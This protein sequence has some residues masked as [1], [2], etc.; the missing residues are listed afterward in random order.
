MAK[1]IERLEIS[2]LFEAMYRLYG[3]DFRDYAYASSR[4]RVLL[5]LQQKKL[6]NVSQLIH[7][8]MH[9]EIAADDLLLALSIN[10]TEMFRDPSFFK[11]L[12]HSILPKFNS[13]RHIKI[14]HAGCSS[15]EEAYSM[16]II[17][18]ELELLEHTQIYAT[19]F[20]DS[21][22]EKAKLGLFDLKKM[23]G[24]IFNYQK[25]SGIEDFA[26]Y[27]Q[28][29]D[30]NAVISKAMKK[31]IMFTHHNLTEDGSFGEMDMIVCRNVLIYF[32]KTLQQRVFRLFSD[33]LV[34]GGY[35]CLGSHETMLFSPVKHL[36]ETVS[37][38]KKIYRKVSEK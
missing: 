31:H 19:D 23:R 17:L 13:K 3:Y 4:R 9:D 22:I 6:D 25:S 27:Y 8:V 34:V 16:A 30:N 1:D 29:I 5:Q 11:M 24:H 14:W 20:N 2:L 12:R 32:D 36:F 28:I 26:S 7:L 15:G 37:E 10:V 35:L 21:I 38:S 18:S 33:S